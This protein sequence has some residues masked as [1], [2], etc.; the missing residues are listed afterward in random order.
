MPRTIFGIAVLVAGLVISVPIGKSVAQQ[1]EENLLENPGFEGVYTIWEVA[2]GTVQIAPEWTPWWIED[3][4]RDPEWSQPEFRPAEVLFEPIRVF[5]GERAQGYFT[6]D[7][8]HFAG[9]Y[10]QVDNVLPG[11]T[12]RFGIWT[13]VW[14]GNSDEPVSDTPNNPHL[15]I[16]I[17]PT[18]AG[19]AGAIASTP[20]TI[21]WGT[22]ADPAC[23]IDQWCFW[24]VEVQ[25][26]STNL[27]VYVR[28]SPDLA[29][30]HN[31]FYFDAAIL[32]PVDAPATFTP[33]ATMVATMTPTPTPTPIPPTT[34]PTMTA[35]TSD[36]PPTP[37]TTKIATAVNT[38]TPTALAIAVTPKSTEITMVQ[39]TP[40]ATIL[41]NSLENTPFLPRWL[42]FTGGG[43]ALMFFFFGMVILVRRDS[44]V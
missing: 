27:T 41:A 15:R 22:E 33:T 21:V 29:S 5:E 38:A 44:R 24:W 42:L 9:I 1:P 39:P 2:D 16:G 32:R 20:S 30:M 8:S 43:L 26:Q 11:V 6:E 34:T 37:F 31:H 25:A 13:Q 35:T 12:Y 14:L 7:V 23:I 36:M 28:S 10:Q 18:G 40:S 17:D 4:E 3:D 19:W